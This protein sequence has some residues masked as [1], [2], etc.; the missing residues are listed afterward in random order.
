[1]GTNYYLKRREP[2]QPCPTCGCTCKSDEKDD[3]HIGKSSWGWCFG[4][5][6]IP[7]L[8]INSLDDWVE[9]IEINRDT[10]HVVDEYGTE[11]SVRELLEFPPDEGA[12][13]NATLR[14]LMVPDLVFSR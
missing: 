10:H 4:L 6:V 11:K 8:G 7:E 1:M 2:Q 3:L 12:M 9:E 13:H 5:H 14:M